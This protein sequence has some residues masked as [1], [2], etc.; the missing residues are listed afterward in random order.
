ME[1]NFTFLKEYWPMLEKMGESAESYLYADPSVCVYKSGQLCEQIVLEIFDLEEIDYVPKTHAS[2]I[3]ML[4]KEGLL[5]FAI[6]EM[7]HAVRTVRNNI[8]HNNTDGTN[9]ASTVLRM[10][11]NLSV[12]FMEVYGD[13]N[14]VKNS[15]KMPKKIETSNIKS[16]LENQEKEIEKLSKA[17]SKISLS[18]NEKDKNERRDKADKAS[19]SMSISEAETRMLIDSQLREVG[20]EV[21]TETMRYSKGVRPQKGKNLAIAEWPTDSK[22]SANGYVDYALFIGLEFVGIIEAKRANIDIPSVIDYQCKE[23]AENIKKEHESYCIKHWGS[24]G[25]PFVF[26]TNGR[27]Y[28]KQLETKSGI[29]FL[30][31]RDPTNQAKALQGWISPAGIKDLLSKNIILGNQ[32][33]LSNPKDFLRDPDG[34]NLR[35]YQIRA[36]EKTEEAIIDGQKNIL[37]SMATGTGKTRTILGIIYRL[38]KNKRFNR[39]LFLVDRTSLGEQ[40]SDVFKEVK[41]EDLLTLDN[42]YNVNEMTDK[43]IAPET[44]IQ[45]ATV[46]SM[47]K[48]ILYNESDTSLSVTDFDLIIVD[49]AHRGYILDKEMS[50]S[51]L[52][53]RNQDD[54]ISKYRTVIEFF[55][56]VKIGLTATPALHTIEIFGKPVFNYSYRE[57]VLDGYLVDHDAPH[58]LS[59]KLSSKGIK[60]K[61]GD[62]LPIY[63]PTTGD[64]TNSSEL[65][66][67]VN[68]DV[69]EFNKKIITENFNRTVLEEIANDLNP[70]GEGKT[71]IYAV[72]DAHADLIVK[73]LHDIYEPYGISNDAVMKITGS[74]A[75]GNKKKISEAIKRFKNERY[76]NIVVTVD[77]LTTG[78]DVPKITTLVFMRRV[79]SRILFE[80]MLGRATRLC[81]EINKTHFEIYDPVRLYED[82]EDV[83]NMKPV[84]TNPYT[85]FEDLITSLVFIK[86]DDEKKKRINQLIAKLQ[87]KV[88][89]ISKESI[90]KFEYI[91]NRTPKEYSVFLREI[92]VENAIKYSTQDLEAFIVLD[93][94]K[95]KRTN[96][97][98]IDGHEDQ[99]IDHYRGYGNGQKPEDY[100]ESFK[101][102]INENIE[103]IAALKM[104]CTKP[105]E[106][107]REELKSLKM[108]LDRNNFSE[109]QLNTAWNALTNQDL[110]IDIIS[111]IRQQALGSNLMTHEQRVRQAIAKLKEK[112]QFNRMQLDWLNRIEK[113]MIHDYILDE[114]TFETGAFKS[115]GGFRKVDRAFSGNLLSYIKEL[116]VYLYE[117]GGF[118]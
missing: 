112:H 66:D 59:T 102:F 9:E 24:Y 14:F 2:R 11:Y 40:A 100:I 76:P 13:W 107:S 79:K 21:N 84:V 103:K 27:K 65:E 89:N 81:P 104:V 58:E 95:R 64:I 86:D 62:V 7:F 12:W 37:L 30:D 42:I 1:S 51:E 60:Y 32:N 29:W 26:A 53:Y 109:L 31:L 54:Y 74:V 97:K 113:T 56:A 105:S 78:I 15:F 96:Y 18:S 111:F 5:P 20:W 116:N 6:S 19:E 22:V 110:V 43:D 16:I 94:D 48:R 73:I 101:Q 44:R 33:L 63:D 36:I 34:L 114:E 23:Y 83:T 45:I 80:Q 77:L 35:E 47:V 41:I 117:D 57:A 82:L 50:D 72:D 3:S 55:D 17:E 118:N 67:D 28:L 61:K 85:S 92:S 68:F 115:A 71:L 75:G 25:V 49:E 8:V 70:E 99:L 98:I 10:T 69:D 106:L 52:L 4:K 91:A 39:I 88:K 46:Q 93:N 90:E 108:E 38:L 87:R